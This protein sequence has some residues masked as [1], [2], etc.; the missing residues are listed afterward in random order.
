MKRAILIILN[1]TFQLF[2]LPMIWLI[3]DS[4]A[5]EALF[6]GDADYHELILSQNEQELVDRVILRY[7]WD[8]VV[9]GTTTV[10]MTAHVE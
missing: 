6:Q 9:Q 1:V 4:K 3:R 5:D 8:E 10:R 2:V 7:S